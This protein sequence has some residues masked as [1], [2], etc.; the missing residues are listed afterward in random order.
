[1]HRW[2][3]RHGRGPA[4][5]DTVRGDESL[6]FALTLMGVVGGTLAFG[7]IGLFLGPVVLSLG[8]DLLQELTRPH[9]ADDGEA[10]PAAAPTERT[11]P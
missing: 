3:D 1:V 7:F 4:A 8:R 11:E 10:L 6:P 9:D 2:S 5:P